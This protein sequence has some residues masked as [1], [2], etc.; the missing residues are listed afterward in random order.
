MANLYK[1][2]ATGASS[3]PPPP[4]LPLPGGGGAFYDQQQYLEMLHFQQQQYHHHPA[5]P[6]PIHHP[7]SHQPESFSDAEKFKTEMCRKFSQTGFCRYGDQCQFAHGVGELRV[8]P[9]HPLY[10]TSSC[11]SFEATGTCRYG[12]RCRFIHDEDTSQLVHVT[13]MLMTPQV[14][15]VLA[16]DPPP[17]PAGV[18]PAN[19]PHHSHAPSM[20]RLDSPPASLRTV[21]SLVGLSSAP[22]K[23]LAVK[24]QGMGATGMP[25]MRSLSFGSQLHE[26][27]VWGGGESPKPP[28]SP[29]SYLPKSA[30]LAS[31]IWALDSTAGG[32][33]NVPNS[34]STIGLQTPSRHGSSVW[35]TSLLPRAKSQESRL[36]KVYQ[37]GGSG[38]GTVGGGTAD[39]PTN[40][41]A[42]Q[43]VGLDLDSEEEEE[44]N[45]N[46]HHGEE[47]GYF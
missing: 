29:A 45:H 26:S 39:H 15:A 7:L 18:S 23:A 36:D 33:R 3:H 19:S 5:A 6:A 13:R 34:S 30:S 31:S 10:K 40:N 4:S 12:I 47:D 24:P 1:W 20:F 44:G 46:H 2:T 9:K 37:R 43:Q 32:G 14:A 11:K 8:L 22:P 42:N 27:A 28:V 35:D 21:R 16:E 17:V 38:G 25:A 41:N